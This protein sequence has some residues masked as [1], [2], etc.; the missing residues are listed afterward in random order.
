[1]S[2]TP[3]LK[4]EMKRVPLPEGVTWSEVFQVLLLAAIADKKGYSDEKLRE[5]VADHPHG[6]VIRTWLKEVYGDFLQDD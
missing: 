1:M 5:Q 3:Y 4:K 2:L 6:V